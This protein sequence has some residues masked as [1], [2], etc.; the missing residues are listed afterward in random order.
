[1]TELIF[2]I[3]LAKCASTTLQRRIFLREYGYLGT[4]PPSELPRSRNL[5]KALSN[6]IP[7]SGRQT[8]SKRNLRAWA[9]RIREVHAEHWPETDRLLLSNEF[10]SSASRLNDRPFLKVLELLKKSN[11]PSGN[12]K[13]LLILRNQASRLASHY[14]EGSSAEWAPGQ[15]HFE[16]VV[17]RRLASRRYQRLFDY[18]RWVEGLYAVVGRHN[19]CVLLLEE[20]GTADFWSDIKSFCKLE[21][22]DPDSMVEENSVGSNVRKTSE[23]TWALSELDT[24]FKAK[25]EIDRWLN[26]VWPRK[27]QIESRSALRE[28]LIKRLKT[29]YDERAAKIANSEREKQIHLSEELIFSVRRHCD[30]ANQRLAE[31]LGREIRNFGY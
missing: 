29:Q 17:S 13:V 14:A 28:A 4:A 16:A 2:H 8:I 6:C 15:A 1:M 23:Q 9:E 26:L 31:L 3:G 7:S 30:S 24:G 19:V 27:F 10:F 21:Q 20:A 12:L 22:F 5:A 25:S 18:S 11:W